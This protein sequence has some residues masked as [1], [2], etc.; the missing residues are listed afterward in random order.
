[1]TVE[2]LTQH[3]WCRE[4]IAAAT[5]AAS[6]TPAAATLASPLSAAPSAA[7]TEEVETG[8]HSDEAAPQAEPAQLYLRRHHE[9]LEAAISKAVSSAMSTHARPPQRSVE[10]V[11]AALA[12]GSYRSFE[13]AASG[14]GSGAGGELSTKSAAEDEKA[15]LRVLEHALNAALEACLSARPAD[16]VAFLGQEMA[17]HGQVGGA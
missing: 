7:A 12:S 3:A 14:S 6:A 1:M 8:N 9:A 2:Q 5:A 4:A 13:Q 11:A 15:A 16:P 10:H 17:R